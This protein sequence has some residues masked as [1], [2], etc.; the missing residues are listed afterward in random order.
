LAQFGGP[1]IVDALVEDPFEIVPAGGRA[2]QAKEEMIK[3]HIL[4][5]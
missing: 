5:I 2:E 4:I 1:E 3:A